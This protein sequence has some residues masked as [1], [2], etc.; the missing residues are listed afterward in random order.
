MAGLKHSIH[1]SGSR[2]SSRHSYS[3]NCAGVWLSTAVKVKVAERFGLTAAG[4]SRI[5]VFGGASS[6]PEKWWIV[7]VVLD[8]AR[9]VDRAQLEGEEAFLHDRDRPR[10]RA[11]RPL[12]LDGN[13]IPRRDRL[14]RLGQLELEELALELEVLL[15]GLVVGA[16]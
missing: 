14:G 6:A 7:G 11:R 4:F 8:V 15:G 13:R 10:A 2:E 9:A 12:L 3:M 16:A 1:M 5:S